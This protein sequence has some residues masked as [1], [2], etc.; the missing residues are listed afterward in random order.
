M[1]GM[2]G[3]DLADYVRRK[4]KANR[5]TPVILLT[6]EPVTKEVARKHGCVA[7]FSKAD[8]LRLI[9]MVQILLSL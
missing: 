8:K 1:P 6:S 4:N 5:F 2:S 3:L 7:Y 9:A